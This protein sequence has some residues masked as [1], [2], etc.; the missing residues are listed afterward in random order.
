MFERRLWPLKIGV[1][2]GLAARLEGLIKPKII[3]LALRCYTGNS[4][5]LRAMVKRGAVRID[6]NGDVAGAVSEGDTHGAHSILIL[7]RKRKLEQEPERRQAEKA[8][9]RQEKEK[10]KEKPPAPSPPPPRDGLAA[11]REAALKRRGAA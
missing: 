4:G 2:L 9:R 6:L 10:E 7:R 5:D 1:H 3:G 8:A 11:L